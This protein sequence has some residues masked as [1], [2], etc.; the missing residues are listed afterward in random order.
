MSDLCISSDGLYQSDDDDL[1]W[2]FYSSDEE[3]DVEASEDIPSK[4]DK[5]LYRWYH[6]HDN[7][8]IIAFTLIHAHSVFKS[9]IV[10]AFDSP[11]TLKFQ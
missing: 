3:S 7:N 11:R 9:Q 8:L 6:F 4:E 2:L 1:E 10:F 5:T